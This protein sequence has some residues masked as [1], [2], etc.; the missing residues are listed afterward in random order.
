MEAR[1]RPVGAYLVVGIIVAALIAWLIVRAV[2]KQG[3][4]RQLSSNNLEVRVA[5]ARTL[6]GREQ[7][8]DALPA[9]PVI[10]RSKTAQALGIIGTDD[11]IRA[12]GVILN[13]QEDAPKRWAR[14][15]LVKIGK[16][17]VPVLMAALAASGGT[18][19]EAVTALKQLGP[20]VAPRIRFLLTDRSAYGGAGEALSYLGPV[21]IQ[22]LI[23]G[24]HA[25]DKDLRKVCLNN[26]GL[27]RVQAA[28]PACL[29][30]LNTKDSNAPA[31]NAIT[32]LGN[33][34]D[35]SVA[36]AVIPFL[37]GGDRLAAVTTLGLLRYPGAV[38][39]ILATCTETEKAYR[40]A[41]ILALHR[42]GRP[43]F[44]ALTRTL[45]SPNL[46]LRRAAALAL[47]RSNAPDL[48]GV[49]S[50]ALRDPDEEVRAAAAEALGFPGNL[51]AI[52]PLLAAL[53]DPQW[54]VVDAAVYGLGS[55]GGVAVR[56][57]LDVVS[58]PGPN[59]T[60]R[61]QISRALAVMGR[62]AV[63]A[64]ETA[65]SDPRPE[66]QKWAA[67]TLGEIGDPGS[68]AALQKLAERATG[69]LKWVA[70]DQLRILAGTT[71]F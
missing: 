20:S 28:V 56:P 40:D 70:Q 67:I 47:V 43:A 65:L 69:D 22:A 36:P 64:L 13:D 66:V 41:A 6:L 44:A 3:L 39:P 55:L 45:A 23:D 16:R 42:I 2:E 14:Q 31:G 59:T 68:V 37:K 18:K 54:R 24:C 10:R 48:N 12:L 9:Q 32:A 25:V 26:L 63:P 33:I 57:L 11:A 62:S 52:G 50:A 21:G 15:A 53:S 61:Y 34:G 46:L 5:A 58:G 19:D 8:V 60:V 29:A 17:S 4:I 35:R 49:L 71:S 1:R 30:N 7:L 27:R 51:A 38:D